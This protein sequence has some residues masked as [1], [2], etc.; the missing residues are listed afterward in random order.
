MLDTSPIAPLLQRAR[1]IARASF[2]LR[3]GRTVVE[4][5]FQSGSAKALL[6]KSYE[7]AA[8]VVFVNTAGGITGGDR[9]GFEVGAGDGTEVV[10][11]TQAAERI[12]RATGANGELHNRLTLGTGATLSWLPQETILFEGGRLQRRIHVEMAQDAC[13]LALEPFVFGRKA[14][15]EDLQSGFFA[16]SWRVRRAGELAYADSLRLSGDL[17][18]LTAQDATFGGARAG[19]NLLYVGPDAEDRLAQT[20]TILGDLEGVEAAAS[21]WNGLLCVRFLAGDNTPLRRGLIQFLT[22]FRGSDLP[23]VWHM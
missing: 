23:R 13:L 10:A 15:G 2:R 1:G 3:D 9:F 7:A 8:H 4:N 14:M 6:P 12:Y 5:L 18:A 20:R 11:T 16:D 19:A 21:A 17:A 22:R